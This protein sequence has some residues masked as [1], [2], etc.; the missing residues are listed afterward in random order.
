M[1][2]KIADVSYCPNLSSLFCKINIAST[3]M[4]GSFV[5]VFVVATAMK[6]R[7]YVRGSDAHLLL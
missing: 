5:P 2:S 1:F 7:E 4:F 6:I 3:L